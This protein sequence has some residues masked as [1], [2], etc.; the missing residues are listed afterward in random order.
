[1]AAF[2]D[3]HPDDGA[4]AGA[5]Y[6]LRPVTLRRALYDGADGACVLDDLSDETADHGPRPHAVDAPGR[7]GKVRVAGSS[8]VVR[9]TGTPGLARGFVRLTCGLGLGSEPPPSFRQAIPGSGLP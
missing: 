1:M 5:V 3:E 2:C 8:P 6:R 9:S 4:Q 7:L